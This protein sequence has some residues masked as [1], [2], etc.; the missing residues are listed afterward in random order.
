M[1]GYIRTLAPGRRHTPV[2]WMFVWRRSGLTEPENRNQPARDKLGE[3]LHK[4]FGEVHTQM[5]LDISLERAEPMSLFLPGRPQGL[6][7]EPVRQPVTESL[8][9]RPHRRA[10]PWPK[11]AWPYCVHAPAY[12]AA[13]PPKR[14]RLGVALDA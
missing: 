2:G 10:M 11:A 3:P 7:P 13:P 4:T 5:R 12:R 8:G 1:D 14:Q 9:N 6:V